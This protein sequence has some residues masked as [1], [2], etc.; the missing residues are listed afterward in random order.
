MG[1][2]DMLRSWRERVEGALKAPEH[3]PEESNVNKPNKPNKPLSPSSEFV[4]AG[5]NKLPTNPCVI[6]GCSC[7]IADGDLVYCDGHREKANDGSLW[8]RCVN[9]G[10][11]VAPNNPIVCIEHQAQIDA[12]LMPWEG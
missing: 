7:P 2:T 1:L 11:P 10:S 5:S 6:R 4:D 9:C 8:L 3:S 12:L